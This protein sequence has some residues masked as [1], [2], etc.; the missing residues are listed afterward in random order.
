V[1]PPH[2][3]AVRETPADFDSFRMINNNNAL[4]E[5]KKVANSNEMRAKII[6]DSKC[7]EIFGLKRN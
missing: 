6:K 4:A 1:N 5:G 7:V 2:I 3:N